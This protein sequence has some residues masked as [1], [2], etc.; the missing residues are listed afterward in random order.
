VAVTASEKDTRNFLEKFADRLGELFALQGEKI[1]AT[2]AAGLTETTNAVRLQG[3]RVVQLRPG[4]TVA[5][6]GRGR[7]V[8]W[9]VRSDAG[10][11]LT[12]HD[13]RSTDADVL[14]VIQLAAGGAHTVWF[15][16]GGIS[17]TEAVYLS[18]PAVVTSGAL[19]IGAVD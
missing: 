1:R 8:G 19:Y 4:A 17:I 7:L 13:G 15:G 11:T 14:A 18:A 6:A 3:A 12:L 2:I 5:H 10:G 9:S 16:P